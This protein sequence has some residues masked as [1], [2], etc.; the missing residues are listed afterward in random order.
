MF[1]LLIPWAALLLPLPWLMMRW[2]KKNQNSQAINIPFIEKVIQGNA[3]SNE[4]SQAHFD[5]SKII[6][7]L[8]WV[9]FIAALMRPVWIGDPIPPTQ[10]GRNIMLA[11]DGSRSMEEQ[12]MLVNNRRVNRFMALQSVVDEFIEQRKGDR[13]GLILFGTQ[14]YMLS[15]LSFD[16]QAVQSMLLDA[17]IGL[18]GDNTAIGDAIGLAIKRF[19]DASSDNNIL[20]LVTDGANTSGTV[21]PIDAANKAAEI[22]VK[23]YTIGIG[24]SANA[25]NDPVSQLMRRQGLTFDDSQ[26]K[27]IA[28]ITQG[29]YFL[30]QDA[31]SLQAIYAQLNAIEST[32]YEGQL[33][34]PIKEY[35]WMI[36]LLALALLSLYFMGQ[37]MANWLRGR[38]YD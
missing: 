21:D 37:T 20:I 25:S 31:Q 32:E 9:L 1:S 5:P 19:Q 28:Q 24:S 34:R 36:L 4:L 8:I 16:T 12:D 11:I 18:A 2:S 35:Y 27:S 7:W 6:L 38:S 15:P 13:I 29:Q 23:I 3:S 33:F 17:S 10:E 14:A 22:G 26:L 30:A